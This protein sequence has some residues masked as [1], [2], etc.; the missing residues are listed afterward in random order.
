[1][2]SA[3]RRR[4]PH[5]ARRA[6]RAGTPVRWKSF[7]Y[8][9]LVDFR[10]TSIGIFRPILSTQSRVSPPVHAS[11]DGKEAHD[12]DGPRGF[13]LTRG[14]LQYD[15]CLHH[16]TQLV[17]AAPNDDHQ[18]SS[19]FRISSSSSSSLPIETDTGSRVVLKLESQLKT[20]R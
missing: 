16:S 20:S 15:H 9:S 4:S 8:P 17:A 12:G 3:S 6:K 14:T 7:M 2:M 11:G 10:S 18:N 1:M 13:S 19:V 5:S